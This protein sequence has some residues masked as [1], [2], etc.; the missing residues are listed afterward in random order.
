MKKTVL[1]LVLMTVTSAA[2]FAGEGMWTP[3]NLPK[4]EV[5]AKYNF[6]PDA[7]WSEHVQKAAL[8]LAGGCS[9]S[10]VSPN[11]LVLT[12]HHCVNACVQ[13][14]SSAQ[15][16][17]IKSGFLAKEE[18]DEVRC[19]EIELNRL[20]RIVNVTER[21]RKATAGKSGEDYSKAE[22]AIKSEIEKECVGKDST[23]TRCD[24]VDLYHGGVYDL[25]RY[26]RFQDVR[27]VF[28]PELAMAFFG[29]VFNGVSGVLFWSA[30]GIAVAGQSY[31]RAVEQARR[32]TEQT[33][34][35]LDPTYARYF[36]A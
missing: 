36:A 4:A 18:K 11:G 1:A 22:K 32:L 30:V 33:G 34:A 19:P 28:A 17:Y 10:F 9:G 7:K 2:A 3:D 20:D 13:Q 21:V 24:A 35:P 26:H 23:G 5:Q 27:L 16:D 12:N 25:Y 14:L 31:A 8:R 29:N 15:N 6:T